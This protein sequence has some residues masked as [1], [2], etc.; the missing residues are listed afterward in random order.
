MA[1]V[2]ILKGLRGLRTKGIDYSRQRLGEL[3]EEG[4]FPP[5]DGRTTD[6]PFSPPWWFETTIDKHLKKRAAKFAAT[7]KTAVTKEAATP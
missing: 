2:R 4:L 7:A 6:S 5:P 1:P 3:V